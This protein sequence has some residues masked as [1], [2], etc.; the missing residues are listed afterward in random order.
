[1][2]SFLKVLLLIFLFYF[3][4]VVPASA[5]SITMRDIPATI[6]TD[7]FILSVSVEGATPGINYLRVDIYKGGTTNYFGETFTGNDWYSG[8][9][10]TKYFPITIGSDKTWAGTIQARIGDTIPND[11][12]GSGTYSVRIRRYTNETNYTSAE[13]VQVAIAFPTF[14]PTPTNTPTP[15]PTEKPTKT[16]Q[17]TSTPKPEKNS[18]SGVGSPGDSS[19][20]GESISSESLPASVNPSIHSRINA[21][22]TSILIVRKTPTKIV[23]QSPKR[24]AEKNPSSSL[25]QILMICVGG[26]LFISC[27]ILMYI[28]K[29]HE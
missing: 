12:D 16:P 2:S 1:M 27:G 14:T 6:G 9:D 18:A 15:V 10:G 11:Y 7:P 28:K 24:Q 21:G 17:P 20:L 23:T 8:S 13:A 4:F 19:V 29:K 26:V 22:P 25:P 5:V 3:I